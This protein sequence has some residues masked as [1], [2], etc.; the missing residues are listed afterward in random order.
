[1]K[2]K[3]RS[4][5]LYLSIVYLGFKI[6]NF[7]DRYFNIDKDFVLGLCV[8]GMIVYIIISLFRKVFGGGKRDIEN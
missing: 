4:L 1:M 8:L 2:K 6:I 3:I 5:L 7:A